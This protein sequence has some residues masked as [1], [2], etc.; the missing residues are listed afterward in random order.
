MKI[1]ISRT[2]VDVCLKPHNHVKV[3]TYCG[4]PMFFNVGW[5]TKYYL[6]KTNNSSPKSQ[7]CLLFFIVGG[8]TNYYFLLSSALIII[9]RRTNQVDVS[10]K[11][12]NHDKV[13][14]YCGGPL[15]FKVGRGTKDYLYKTSNNPSKNQL[16]TLSLEHKVRVFENQ[17]LRK[18]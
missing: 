2:Q 13:S 4:G 12:H 3:S 5:G 15:V 1:K 9:R 6:Y 8:E 10:L 16:G 11:P 17:A 7:L 18:G 14:T